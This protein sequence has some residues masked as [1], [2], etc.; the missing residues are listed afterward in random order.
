MVPYNPADPVQSA[1]LTALRLGESGHAKNAATLGVG[2]KDLLNYPRDEWGFPKWE[3]YGHPVS[4]AAGIYQ[5][6]PRTWQPYAAKYGL[7]FHIAQDQSAAAWYLAQDVCR[8]KHLDLCEA[9]ASKQYHAIEHVL[10]ATWTSVTGNK[11]SCGLAVELAAL[12]HA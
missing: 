8:I 2:G 6:Q 10:S 9:L 7:N 1:F 12:L 11:A 3:G 5:F 4:H